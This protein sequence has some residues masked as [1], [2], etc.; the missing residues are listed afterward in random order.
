MAEVNWDKQNWDGKVLVIEDGPGRF[1]N[2]LFRAAATLV[3]AAKQNRPILVL[4]SKLGWGLGELP[5]LQS[6]AGLEIALASG[7]CRD[8][9]EEELC[10]PNGI[11]TSGCLKKMQDNNIIETV[12]DGG[13]Y[14]L[15]IGVWGNDPESF[16]PMLREA[17]SV[18]SVVADLPAQPGPDD[19]ALYFRS[20]GRGDT[21]IFAE[22]SGYQK[23]LSPPIEFFKRAIHRHKALSSGH[24]DGR[25]WVVAS[26]EQRQ[27]PTVQRLVREYD[28]VVYSAGDNLPVPWLYDFAWLSAARHVVISP[29][30]FGWWAAVLGDPERV[31]FPIM[32]GRMPI[33][34]CYL[35]AK[36]AQY[37][38]LDWWT[39]HVYSGG[40]NQTEARQLCEKYQT[41]SLWVTETDR[42]HL[43]YPELV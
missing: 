34:W 3:A 7:I 18:Q 31:Y 6:T 28:A 13:T 36:G 37:K 15:N 9:P 35:V 21:H 19:L 2:Q 1:G 25:V 17:F 5:C 26:P 38:Y 16:F 29:S 32:P 10:M 30:T 14:K 39:G 4:K 33:R 42:F 12:T 27:H 23:L 41:E 11:E 43:F 24:R 40:N 20:W 22:L 8:W